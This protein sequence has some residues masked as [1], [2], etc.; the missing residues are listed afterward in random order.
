MLDNLPEPSLSTN[1]QQ[2]IKDIKYKE[3]SGFSVWEV[4]NR[5]Q[6]NVQMRRFKYGFLKLFSNA[7]GRQ[8]VESLIEDLLGIHTSPAPIYDVRNIGGSSR[9]DDNAH[10]I[11]FQIQEIDSTYE[12]DQ[13]P[14]PPQESSDERFKTCPTGYSLPDIVDKHTFVPDGTCQL[15]DGNMLLIASRKSGFG[16][17]SERSKKQLF[18]ECCTDLTKQKE[19]AGLILNAQQ[20]VLFHFLRDD[21]E[22]TIV[23][24]MNTYDFTRPETNNLE[25]LCKDILKLINQ[26]ENNLNC[27]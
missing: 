9:S 6:A 2:A 4:E 24:R 26:V 1:L 23:T 3:L 13:M 16:D 12:D 27:N 20:A 18:Y 8:A 19:V 14:S 22:S 10:L 15:I 25:K 21:T 11:G 17:I 5:L 7:A